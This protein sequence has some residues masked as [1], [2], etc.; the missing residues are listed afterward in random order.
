MAEDSLQPHK[1]MS[2]I[3]NC[4]SIATIAIIYYIFLSDTMNGL[5]VLAEDRSFRRTLYE[6]GLDLLIEIMLF[7]KSPI[8]YQFRRTPYVK[9][10]ALTLQPK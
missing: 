9:M 5:C 8:N 1:W 7:Y 6:N 10:F 3:F 2:V 4:M